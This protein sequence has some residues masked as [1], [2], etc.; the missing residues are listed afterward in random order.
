MTEDESLTNLRGWV[1]R[2][3]LDGECSVLAEALQYVLDLG[4]EQ[5]HPR[6]TD[7]YREGYRQALLVVRD[8]VEN[9]ILP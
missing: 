3:A 2:H 9:V 5:P 8:T 6:E 1:S 4:Q 7:D